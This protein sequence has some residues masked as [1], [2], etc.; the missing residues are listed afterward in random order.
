MKRI[1]TSVAVAL[2]LT[3]TGCSVAGGMVMGE[4]AYNH[5]RTLRERGDTATPRQSV[6]SATVFGVALGLAIDLL[7]VH[8][9]SRSIEGDGC[10]GRGCGSY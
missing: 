4:R 5:N 9:L 6:E 10:G 8:E 1:L 2:A 7:V 3:S